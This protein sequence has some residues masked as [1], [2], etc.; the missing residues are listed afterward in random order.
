MIQL[1]PLPKKVS[2][3]TGTFR[4]TQDTSCYFAPELQE[5]FHFFKDL[6]E[7]AARFPLQ[8]GNEMADIRFLYDTR[9]PEEGY[10]L[11]CT[12]SGIAV[13]SSTP[14]GAFY[15]VQTL[16]QLL[17]LDVSKNAETLSMACVKIEDAPRF[18]WRGMMLDSSRYFWSVD[19]VKRYLDFMAMHKLNVFHWHLTDDAVGALK[20]K[21]IRCSRR[22]ALNARIHSCTAGKANGWR[23]SPTHPGFY[24]QEQIREI[25]AYAAERFIMVVPE[26]D[27]PAHFAAAIAAYPYLACRE[28]PSE[29]HWFYGSTIRKKRWAG[30]IGTAPPAQARR[31][32]TNSSSMFWM[33]FCPSF[34]PPIST[35]AAMKR[36]RTSGKPAR[37]AKRP[38][39]RMASRMWRSYRG[40]S[41]T[42]LQLISRRR[43][44]G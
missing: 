28:I 21:N 34:P 41:T 17:K 24:T 26:V 15:A 35:L 40:Y 39:K 14:A 43:A 19:Y 7:K 3:L 1:I 16:R 11:D 13:F 33:K 23:E 18:R 38:S 9:I 8:K 4:L 29:V 32:P 30:R 25:V 37:T 12:Q 27:M 22:S 36:R 20:S 44:N 5:T 10:Q 2:Q 6:V 31:A 42:V